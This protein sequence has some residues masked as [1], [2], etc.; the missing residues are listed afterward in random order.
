VSTPTRPGDLPP[1]AGLRDLADGY[2]RHAL[3]LVEHRHGIRVLTAEQLAEHALAALAY[4]HALSE[5]ALHSRWS[6]AA[7]ALA[8]R[9]S[10][11]VVGAAMGGLDADE[12][13]AGLGRWVRGQR[14]AGLMPD[15]RCG[16]VLGFLFD[17][18][19]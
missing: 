1:S 17:T 10:L 8:A 19:R 7:D 4:S 3:L 18:E 16:Q 9:T 11:E 6:I 13:R 12:L 15:E 14:Q 2:H 5:R